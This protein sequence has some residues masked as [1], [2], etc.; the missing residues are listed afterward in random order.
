MDAI[1]KVAVRI[2]VESDKWTLSAVVKTVYRTGN[3]LRSSFEEETILLGETH[4]LDRVSIRKNVNLCD[5]LIPLN[6]ENLLD[7]F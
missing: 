5:E 2:S 4:P 1:N 3:R 7:H 6:F